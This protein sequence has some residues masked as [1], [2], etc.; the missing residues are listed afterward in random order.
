MIPLDTLLAFMLASIILIVIPGSSVLFAIGRSIAL[1]RRAGVLSVVGNTLGTV[2][3]VIA[4]SLGV[5][6]VI[7]SSLVAFTIIKFVGAAYLVW[8][9]VQ[10]IRRRHAHLTAPAAEPTSSLTL[11]REGFIVGLTN[12]K[13]IA[14]FVAVLPQF[15]TPA[16]GPA[17]LQMLLLGLVFV[18]IAV[19]SDSL[20]ALAAGMARAWFARSPRRLSTLSGAGGAML[21]GLGGALAFAESANRA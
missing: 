8:L 17:W 14:F 4:V 5:G 1:G 19:L 9:G 11:L 20:W 21:I 3:I 2:P 12:P 7:A 10:A 18:T 15:V 6:A 16:S 13:T